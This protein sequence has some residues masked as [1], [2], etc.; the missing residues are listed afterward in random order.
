MNRDEGSYQLSHIYDYL[1]FAT[2]TPGG[3]SLQQRQQRLPKHQQKQWIQKLYFDE[4]VN[5]INVN[6]LWM[7]AGRLFQTHGLSTT[8]TTT[9]SSTTATTTTA[10]KN[11]FPD[12]N[13]AQHIMKGWVDLGVGCIS[14]W[15]ICLLWLDLSGPTSKRRKGRRWGEKGKWKR[16]RWGGNTGSRR[17]GVYSYVI[18]FLAAPLDGL[19]KEL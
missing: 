14:R 5:L 7:G 18:P 2:A 6:L 11:T 10:S 3:Q 1:L 15:L 12:R 17:E 16:R 13:V 9:T 19:H 8:T 4:F